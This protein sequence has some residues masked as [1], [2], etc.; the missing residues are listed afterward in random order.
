M[1]FW[2]ILSLNPAAYDVQQ[3]KR[4]E[5]HESCIRAF[6]RRRRGS[7]FL[8]DGVG[9]WSSL[10]IHYTVPLFAM[11]LFSVKKERG[12]EFKMGSEFIMVGES[13][14]TKK[15]VKLWLGFVRILVTKTPISRQHL[16]FHQLRKAV[17]AARPEDSESDRST[18]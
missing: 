7:R 11:P 3:Q 5:F 8:A 1:I 12:K 6:R 14:V 9:P 13:V 10:L 15:K 17:A 18:L 16:P 2:I 4:F